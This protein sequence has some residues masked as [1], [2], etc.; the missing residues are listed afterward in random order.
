MGYTNRH[1][2]VSIKILFPCLKWPDS[3]LGGGHTYFFLCGDS[4]TE[5]TMSQIETPNNFKHFFLSFCKTTTPN[6]SLKYK[7]MLK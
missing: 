2:H 4:I 7:G 1:S 5:S 6:L 3:N